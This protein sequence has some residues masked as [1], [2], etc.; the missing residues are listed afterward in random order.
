MKSSCIVIVLMVLVFVSACGGESSGSS[1]SSSSDTSS[2]SVESVVV[3]GVGGTNV[4]NRSGQYNLSISGVEHNITITEGNAVNAL[5]IS[6]VSNRV[7]IESGVTVSSLT[8]SG[9]NNIVFVPVDSSISLTSRTGV[10]NELKTRTTNSITGIWSFTYPATQCVETYNFKTDGTF[11][12]T[13]LDEV[14]GGTYIFE[15]TVVTGTR[16]LLSLAI[17]ADN[18]L[19]DCNGLSED[20]SGMNATIYQ[21]HKS[22]T[23]IE[24]F[25]AL[26]GGSV[27]GAL[28]KQ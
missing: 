11:S 16:H 27:L 19:S 24:W 26:E 7:I 4:I 8:I 2:L 23:V 12:V 5:T 6:G 18:G 9:S 22:A 25:A 13:S 21:N 1:D 3:S 14:A 17:T 28:T 15:E 20:N 10:G